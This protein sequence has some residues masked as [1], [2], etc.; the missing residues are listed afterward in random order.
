[1]AVLAVL[2]IHMDSM[3]VGTMNPAPTNICGNEF[4][5]TSDGI[6]EVGNPGMPSHKSLDYRI[7]YEHR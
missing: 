2:E 7:N 6:S 4:I 5:H 3:A 1:M